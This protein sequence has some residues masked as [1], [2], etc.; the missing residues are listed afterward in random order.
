[1][2][3]LSF[4]EEI[5]LDRKIDEMQSLA[6]SF[7]TLFKKQQFQE[8]M[9]LA[10]RNDPSVVDMALLCDLKVCRPDASGGI[11]KPRV[12][13]QFLRLV[14]SRKKEDRRKI[15]NSVHQMLVQHFRTTHEFTYKGYKS[16]RLGQEGSRQHSMP[17]REEHN[18][19][20]KLAAEKKADNPRLSKTA[21]A[22]LLI[23]NDGVRLKE[24]TIR[25]ILRK[26]YVEPL[27]W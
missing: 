1:M 2:V 19:I 27:Q 7:G 4:E 9:Q 8:A 3:E 16:H 24:R 10:E 15:T 14:E 26:P 22:R 12:I 5:E 6:T 13:L 21:L 25:A 17:F 11:L 20:R 18:R 23:A